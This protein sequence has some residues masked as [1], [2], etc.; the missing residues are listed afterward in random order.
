[1]S[2]VAFCFPGQ[3]SLEAGMG[4]DIAEAVPAAREVYRVGSEASGLDLERLC[5]EAPL[6]ELVETE[7]QQP[8]LVDYE[9][10]HPRCAAGARRSSPTSSSATRSASSQRLLRWARSGP[11]R[12]SDS[13][14]SAVSRWPKRRDSARARWR[15]SSAWR[16]S[17]WRRSAARSSASGPR[18]TTAPGRSSSPARTR[19]SRSAAPRPRASAPDERSDS[20]SRAHSTARSSRGRPTAS[21]RRSTAF[22]SP[23]PIAPFMSTVTAKIEPAQRLAGSARRPADRPGAVHAG[24]ARADARAA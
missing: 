16:T 15:R 11:E 5:F 12:R 9:P 2:K 8:A 7:V 6:E 22:A 1:M 13:F 21:S 4:K 20:R 10:R 23:S 18:T 3:G 24:G 19:R 17:R 14:V